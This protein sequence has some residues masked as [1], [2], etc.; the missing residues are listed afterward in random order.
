MSHNTI[1]QL[2]APADTDPRLQPR[3]DFCAGA[4]EYWRP[5]PLR[6]LKWP[7]HQ[8]MLPNSYGGHNCRSWLHSRQ[9][10]D[11]TL[12]Q[13]SA[14][15]GRSFRLTRCRSQC[16]CR[17]LRWRRHEDPCPPQPDTQPKLPR[18]S[19]AM[20]MGTLNEYGP[21]RSGSPASIFAST[22]IRMFQ[23]QGVYKLPL[24]PICGELPAA[25]E[26]I[27]FV[28]ITSKSRHQQVKMM[29]MSTCCGPHHKH[30]LW[31]KKDDC[32]IAG[33]VRP[34]F[35]AVPPLLIVIVALLASGAVAMAGTI[36]ACATHE[37]TPD[38]KSIVYGKSVD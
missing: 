1:V 16:L 11:N 31:A 14:H 9:S 7:I 10:G 22:C 5:S 15:R 27:E 36:G 21:L 24:A 3:V 4:C 17:V 35:K 26:T 29:L 25:F 8:R 18:V 19:C 23:C 34:S 6:L 20:Y 12:R 38:R 30:V 13:C 37:K 33:P 32:M 2:A 28:G